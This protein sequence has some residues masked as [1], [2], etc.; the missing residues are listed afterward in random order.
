M[1]GV[2]AGRERFTKSNL[3]GVR[4]G[5]GRLHCGHVSMIRSMSVFLL[6]GFKPERMCGWCAS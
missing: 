3:A 1:Y 5:A 4:H 2:L 6:Q